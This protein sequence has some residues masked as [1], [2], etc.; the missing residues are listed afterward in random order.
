[1]TD[2][3]KIA[4]VIKNNN[5]FAIAVHVNPDSDCLGSSSALLLALRAM[6]KEAKILLSQKNFAY[7]G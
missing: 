3:A 6:N 5:S 7:S 4:D 2:I 1:M